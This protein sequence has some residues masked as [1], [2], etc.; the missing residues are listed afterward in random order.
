MDKM[1]YALQKKGFLSMP[2]RNKSMYIV[3]ILKDLLGIATPF[4]FKISPN[5][6]LMLLPE[7]ALLSLS[8]AQV[9]MEIWSRRRCQQPKHV[10]RLVDNDIVAIWLMSNDICFTSFNI[11]SIYFMTT[12]TYDT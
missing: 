8:D 5:L 7:D 6:T 1:I 12:Y 4:H 10:L 11:V 3:W 2:N 9:K